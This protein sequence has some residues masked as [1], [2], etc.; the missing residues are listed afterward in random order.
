MVIQILLPCDI[1]LTSLYLLYAK[2]YQN[3]Q[4]VHAGNVKLFF[5]YKSLYDFA[6][7]TSFLLR[8]GIIQNY[9][10]NIFITKL[11]CRILKRIF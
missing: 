2:Y 8:L 9:N 3:L 7:D 5:G 1:D 11:K 6:L 4:A 10:L